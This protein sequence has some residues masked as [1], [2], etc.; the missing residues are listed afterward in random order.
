MAVQR[1]GFD[2]VWANDVWDTAS[3]TYRDNIR[4][5][6]IEPGDIS[7]FHNFPKADFLFGC[8]PCQ[9][10]S[11]GGR[12]DPEDPTNYLY[13]HF[14]RVLRHVLPK[15]FVVENVNGMAYGD[16]RTLLMNQVRRYRMAGYRVVWKVLDAK[17]YGVA[18]TRRRVFIVGIRS[19]IDAIYEFPAP[20][21]RT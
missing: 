4:N 17:D 21:S 11:Q 20:H 7:N 10:Y 15:A 9:G 19:D 3:Q 2:I 14:D 5:S 8:Y 12:R 18:Q 1:C 16:N 13:R 6:K